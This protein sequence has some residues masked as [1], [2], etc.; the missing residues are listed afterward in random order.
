MRKKKFEKLL[1]KHLTNGSECDIIN[2][3]SPRGESEKENRI[4]KIEQ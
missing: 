2:E 4:L 3:L 1:K